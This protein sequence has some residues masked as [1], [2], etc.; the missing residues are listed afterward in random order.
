MPSYFSIE[1]AFPY[2][3]LNSTFVSDFYSAIFAKYPFKTG[4]WNSEENTLEEIIVWNQKHLENKFI[5][6]YKEHVSNNYKQILLSSDTFSEIRHFWSYSRNE[7][8]SSIII[9]E[10]DVL[11]EE[12]RWMFNANRFEQIKDMCKHIWEVCPVSILQ[13]CLEFD[14]GPINTNKV[15]TGAQPSIN[16]I[17]IINQDTFKKITESKQNI[18]ITGIARRGIM[19]IDKGLL[20]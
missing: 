11:V 17:C 3:D 2:Q 7:I 20:E 12:D 8:R 14:G 18:E 13:S 5:L 6:G 4:Y 1:L 15:K 16:P 19:L 9:P 10:F